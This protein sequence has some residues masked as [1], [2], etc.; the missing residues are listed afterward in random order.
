MNCKDSIELLRQA[1]LEECGIDPVRV[2]PDTDLL[3]DLNID[4]LAILNVAFWIEGKTGLKLPVQEWISWQYDDN[5][6]GHSQFTVA[7]ICGFLDE[8]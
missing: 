1:L 3:E 4:S 8:K 2:Q 7:N 5:V 6:S